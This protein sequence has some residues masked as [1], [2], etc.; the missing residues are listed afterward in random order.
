LNLVVALNEDLRAPCAPPAAVNELAWPC[1]DSSPDSPGNSWRLRVLLIAAQATLGDTGMSEQ[2]NQKTAFEPTDWQV[3]PIAGIY[4]GVLVLL[5]ISCFVLII[6]YPTSLPD[7][8][9]TLRIHP[10]GPRLQTDPA[11]DLRQFRADEEK[12]LHTYYWIDKQKGVVHIPIE[13]AMKKL[14]ET[15]ID[16]FQKGQQ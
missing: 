6:A 12:R 10:P 8:G 7:V 2:Q 1:A 13:Q 14:S 11:R 4:I 15:G 3:A 9:R 5:V 16:G